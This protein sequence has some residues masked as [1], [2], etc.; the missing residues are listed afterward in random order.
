M[1]IAGVE[2]GP[3]GGRRSDGDY[4]TA[5]RSFGRAGRVRAL[6][7][8]FGAPDAAARRRPFAP[9]RLGSVQQVEDV[10][11]DGKRCRQSRRLDAE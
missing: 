4:A 5:L 2:P 10:L 1:T 11:A 3:L 9:L 6:A 8:G 7:R